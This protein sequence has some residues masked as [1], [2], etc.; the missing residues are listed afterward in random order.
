M[1]MITTP[2][3]IH[4]FLMRTQLSAL[5]LENMGLKHSK[6]NVYK[7]VKGVYHLTG[8]R[9][10]VYKKFADMVNEAMTTAQG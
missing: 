7:H 3:G 5:R 6:G 9:V 10:E 4:W 8:S 2:A 1:S